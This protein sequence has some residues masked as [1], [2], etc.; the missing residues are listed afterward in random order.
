[1]LWCAGY[2]AT[3]WTT[4]GQTPGDRVMQIRVTRPD[5]SRLHVV[6]AIGRVGATFLAA[7]PLFAGFVP[8]VLTERRRGMHDWL[9]DT[10]VTRAPATIDAARAYARRDVR[11]SRRRPG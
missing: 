3:F 1:M 5:G 7:L 8:I 2:F 11:A 9:A 6:R 10:I 4:T